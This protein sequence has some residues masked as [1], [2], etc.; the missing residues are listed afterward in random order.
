MFRRKPINERLAE[1]VIKELKRTSLIGAGGLRP[2]N[3]VS[4]EVSTSADGRVNIMLSIVNEP[5]RNPHV[6]EMR[7]QD[8]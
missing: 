1:A 4:W 2:E 5:Y 3:V 6:V 8:A 7:P